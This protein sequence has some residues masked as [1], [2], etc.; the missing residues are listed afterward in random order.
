[1]Q[2]T[3]LRCAGNRAD[4]VTFA[5]QARG[6]LLPEIAQMIRIRERLAGDDQRHIGACAC[7]DRQVRALLRT[8]PSQPDRESARAAK[9]PLDRRFDTVF[10]RREQTRH[11]PEARVL[12]A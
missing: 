4:E 5:H 12:S 8:D 3:S 1:M 7:I 9:R 11:I 6:N 10:D 2:Q